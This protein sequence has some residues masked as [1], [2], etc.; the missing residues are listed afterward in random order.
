VTYELYELG[1]DGEYAE[2]PSYTG[3]AVEAATSSSAAQQTQ[4][5]T[6]SN[7]VNGTYKLVIKKSVHLD[8]V[9]QGIVINSED[10]DLTS[11]S[12][13]NNQ[14]NVVAGTISLAAGDCDGNGAIN[15]SDLSA[16]CD[17]RTYNESV[18]NA[19]YPQADIDGNG[20]INSGDASILVST[21]NYNM[22][23]NRFEFTIN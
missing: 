21:E 6:I 20:V 22:Q 2:T 9:I 13:G 16:V 15:S 3:V 18:E 7:I 10:V 14:S 12:W 11:R 4:S 19:L 23:T 5:F 8:Y 1:G 17:S